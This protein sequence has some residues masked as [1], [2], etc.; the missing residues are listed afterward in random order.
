MMLQ[1]ALQIYRG[2]LIAIRETTI[3][4]GRLINRVRNTML[5]IRGVISNLY[6]SEMSTNRLLGNLG[7]PLR[8]PS[9]KGNGNQMPS[10]RH[11]V[12]IRSV[13]ESNDAD[14][15]FLRYYKKKKQGNDET[16]ERRG[17][18]VEFTRGQTKF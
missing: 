3:I 5:L 12:S 11:F 7:G 14:I 18:Y 4:V 17:Q 2:L 10:N 9:A 15:K 6:S 8:F 16:R 13:E 1:L